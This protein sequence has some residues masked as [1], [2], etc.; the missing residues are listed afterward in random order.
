M[1]KL[2]SKEIHQKLVKRLQE[3]KMD[4]KLIEKASHHL[5]VTH[6]KLI[7][8]EEYFPCGIVSPDALCARGRIRKD[9]LGRLDALLSIEDL[10][11]VEIFPVGII[12]PEYLVVDAIFADEG[13]RDRI[14]A[15]VDRFQR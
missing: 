13:F 1:T 7:D 6:K 5:A 2:S 12:L 8:W 15:A 14:G 9:D 4:A 10:V 3:T 11:K